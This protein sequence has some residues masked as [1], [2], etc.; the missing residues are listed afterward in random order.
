[1]SNQHAIVL[2]SHEAT[3]TIHHNLAT[4]LLVVE[5]NN[6]G[7]NL[8]LISTV[9]GTPLLFYVRNGSKVAEGRTTR[10]SQRT[11]LVSKLRSRNTAMQ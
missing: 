10:S 3:L 5:R 11:I 6:K 4:Q 7:E 2:V 1:M 8:V 9:G